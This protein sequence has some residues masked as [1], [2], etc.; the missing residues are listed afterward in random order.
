M[1]P[2]GERSLQTFR[3]PQVYL[4]IFYSAFK[5]SFNLNASLNVCCSIPPWKSKEVGPDATAKS[6]SDM[7]VLHLAQLIGLFFRHSDKAD[8]RAN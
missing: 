5:L 2:Q 3:T 1:T 8:R 4:Q 6:E 7:K